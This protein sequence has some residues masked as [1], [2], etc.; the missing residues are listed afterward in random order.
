MASKQQQEDIALIVNKIIALK[1]MDTNSDVSLLESQINN[2]VYEL[3]GLN[4]DEIKIVE[5]E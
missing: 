4:E 5:G 3:F 2:Y 1:Q